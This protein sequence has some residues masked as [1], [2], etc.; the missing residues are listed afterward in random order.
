[1]AFVCSMVCRKF[2][3][4]VLDVY[5]RICILPFIHDVGLFKFGQVFGHCKVIANK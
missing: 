5:K 1:M 2:G 4:Q 3:M